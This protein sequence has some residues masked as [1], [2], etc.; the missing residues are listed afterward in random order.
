MY[1]KK[2]FKCTQINFSPKF[3]TYAEA[4]LRADADGCGIFWDTIVS[5]Y[6]E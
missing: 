2:L 1:V 3:Q 5:P 6:G 4:S